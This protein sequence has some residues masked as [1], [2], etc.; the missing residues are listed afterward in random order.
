MS[1]EKDTESRWI[2]L[3]DYEL[4]S[5]AKR[6]ARPERDLDSYPWTVEDHENIRRMVQEMTGRLD[7]VEQRQS[8][9]YRITHA[10][11]SSVNGLRYTLI[12]VAIF[13]FLASLWQKWFS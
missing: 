1:I 11:L 7:R 3:N 6:D 10:T 8:V 9:L 4:S 5:N 13:A 2:Q 12:L